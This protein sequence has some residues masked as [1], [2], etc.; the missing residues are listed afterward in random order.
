MIDLH[1]HILPGID[2]G[3]ADLKESLEM[4]ALAVE[5]G[6]KTQVLTPHIHI[7]RYA[8]DQGSIGAAFDAFRAEACERRISI[9]LR[10]AAE[11]RIGPEIV[12]LLNQG[13]IP[14]LGSWEGERVFLMEFPHSQ[15]PSGSIN[16]VRWLRARGVRPM[17]VH[18]ERNRE[19]Q[20]SMAKLAPFLKAGC[21]IQITA[22]SLAGS[23]GPLPCRLGMELLKAGQ[24]SV[25][26][27]DC[28]NLTYRPPDLGKGLAAAAALIG[29]QAARALVETNPARLLGLA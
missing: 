23:F 11:I 29:D 16:L 25:L 21:L 5:Q 2:D 24:V 13:R 27:T 18:P 6:V 15:V 26:A 10:F 28:H 3:A 19:L 8:N 7:G 9:D 1:S 17:I 4:L 20:V 12:G 22:A 14:W